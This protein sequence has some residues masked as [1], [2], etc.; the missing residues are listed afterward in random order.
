MGRLAVTFA[1][2]GNDRLWALR[3]DW[4]TVEGADANSVTLQPEECS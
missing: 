1:C 3:D 4:A 2:G